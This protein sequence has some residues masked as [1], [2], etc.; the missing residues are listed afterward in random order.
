[1]AKA[2]LRTMS[3][4]LRDRQLWVRPGASSNLRRC[5]LRIGIRPAAER[6][7]NSKA[8]DTTG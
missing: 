1:M 4:S 5:T 2:K 6:D 7:L 3:F 8:R